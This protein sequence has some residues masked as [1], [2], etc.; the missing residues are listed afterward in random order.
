MI[1]REHA[2][3]GTN[4]HAGSDHGTMIVTTQQR[5]EGVT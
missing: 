4:S 3:D 2:R 5:D 1:A